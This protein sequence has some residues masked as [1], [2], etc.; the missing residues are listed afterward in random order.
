M[1]GNWR[2][3]AP[4]AVLV[5]TWTFGALQNKRNASNGYVRTNSCIRACLPRDEGGCV[6]SV[7]RH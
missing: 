1:P 4:T 5:V 7:I 3:G 2:D 6:C